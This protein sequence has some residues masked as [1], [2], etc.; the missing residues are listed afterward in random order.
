MDGIKLKLYMLAQNPDKYAPPYH[1]FEEKEIYDLDKI[2]EQ[3]IQLPGYEK[4]EY[5][6]EKFLDSRTLWKTFYNVTT[7]K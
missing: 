5:L 3:A 4:H 6:N 1:P 7:M 2:A